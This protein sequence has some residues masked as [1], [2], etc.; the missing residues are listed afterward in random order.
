MIKSIS[1][2]VVA[3]VLMAGSVLAND[4]FTGEDI[5]SVQDANNAVVEAG[6]EINL[7][8]VAGDEQLDEAVEACFR[9]WFGRRSLLLQLLLQPLLHPL[10][11]LLLPARRVPHLLLPAGV[12]HDLQLLQ[13]PAVRLG[14]LLVASDGSGDPSVPR[15][16]KPLGKNPGACSFY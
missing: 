6:L 14:L 12:L 10:L 15:N 2:A 7:D 3:L 4:S 9:G 5:A 1:L 13:L 8:A 11:P 16:Y